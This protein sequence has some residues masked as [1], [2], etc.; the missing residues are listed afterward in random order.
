MIDIKDPAIL[1]QIRANYF[2]TNG[3][4]SKEFSPCGWNSGMTSPIDIVDRDAFQTF[5][6]DQ[7]VSYQE[8]DDSFLLYCANFQRW[9]GSDTGS[10]EFKDEFV[11]RTEE[12]DGVDSDPFAFWRAVSRFVTP[13]TFFRVIEIGYIGYAPWVFGRETNYLAMAITVASNGDF[14]VQ[15]F[16][17]Y[18]VQ[19]VS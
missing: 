8:L 17:D 16:E 4:L 5:L 19:P 3:P 14:I 9:P 11:V 7:G 6:E 12:V 2:G 13:G 18:L 1:A 10:I 15:D